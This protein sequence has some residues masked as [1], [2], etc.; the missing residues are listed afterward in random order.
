MDMDGNITTGK[1]QILNRWIEHFDELLNR[2]VYTY[3]Q[4]E[5]ENCTEG[6]REKLKLTQHEIEE[7]IG[8]LK[9]NSA[10]GISGVPAKLLKRGSYEL[11]D[12]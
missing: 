12:T 10:P 7:A 2:N 6:S 9:H 5:T 11:V 4:S 1:T 8:K 3:E